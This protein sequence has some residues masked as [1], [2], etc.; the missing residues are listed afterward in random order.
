MPEEQVQQPIQQPISQPT[1]QAKIDPIIIPKKKKINGFW[2][3][4][5]LVLLLISWFALLLQTNGILSFSF[6][7][8]DLMLLVPFVIL[9]SC[10]VLRLYR[11]FLYTLLW[12]LSLLIIGVGIWGIAIYHSL[13][14]WSKVSFEDQLLYWPSTWYA[15]TLYFDSIA[16]D[17]SFEERTT[18][19]II[20][21]LYTSDRRLYVTTWVEN[22][23]PVL[24]FTED[25]QWNIIQNLR[26]W[27]TWFLSTDYVYN[28]YFKQL[29]GNLSLNL[30][31]LAFDVV[32]LHAWIGSID[33]RLWTPLRWTSSLEIQWAILSNI[34]IRAP[35][36]VWIDLYYKQLVWSLHLDTMKLIGD[37][38]Y[39][40]EGYEYKENKIKI[41]VNVGYGN[42]T[43]DFLE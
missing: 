30:S 37:R 41:I 16:G 8:F 11:W 32:K 23:F 31:H 21:A 33:V 18:N 25:K 27:L 36:D 34:S 4:I 9:F 5:T 42:F 17:Y 22:T 7:N 10:I 20:E 26:S 29:M 35:K 6:W 2:R 39:Q 3:N 24:R 28:L 15:Y 40:S 1:Q 13:F 43:L 38:H 19:R 14:P 12:I